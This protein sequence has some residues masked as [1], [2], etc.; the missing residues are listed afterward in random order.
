MND[1]SAAMRQLMA[2]VPSLTREA[3][4]K[5]LDQ[6]IEGCRDRFEKVQGEVAINRLQG[7]I[8]A[9]RRLRALAMPPSNKEHTGAPSI[10]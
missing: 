9:Y 4:A 6:A 5:V 2:E 3:L 1:T 10:Y 8:E 7:E